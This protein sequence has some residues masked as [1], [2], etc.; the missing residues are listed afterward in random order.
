[1]FYGL[2]PQNEHR[3]TLAI[4]E[5]KKLYP[6]IFHA[7]HLI[8]LDRTMSF[9]TDQPFMEAFNGAVQSQQDSSIIWRLHTLAWAADHCAHIPGDFVECGVYK[10]FCSA[11]LTKYLGFEKRD[12]QYYLYDTYAG[13][14][15]EHL[16]SSPSKSGAFQEDGLYDSVVARFAAYPNVQVVQGMVPDSFAKACPDKIA[17]LHLDMNSV[18][19][20]ISALEVLWEKI[21]PGGLLVLD[22]GGW[23]TYRAQLEAEAEFLGRRGHTIMELPT[24]QGLAIKRAD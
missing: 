13:I 8:A 6:R 20:E 9:L 16:A 1:M 5:I 14:P 21:S 15:E 4:N 12:K 10:G 19:A 24:G 22:D 11:V 2:T 23:V 18:Q 17:F 7:D 3:L